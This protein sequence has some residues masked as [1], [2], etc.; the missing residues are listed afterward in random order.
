MFRQFP[1]RLGSLSAR[2]GVQQ[3]VIA[4]RRLGEEAALLAAANG[5]ALADEARA[6][7]VAER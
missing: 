6:L 2:P 3:L 7:Q 1:N 4:L 5:R